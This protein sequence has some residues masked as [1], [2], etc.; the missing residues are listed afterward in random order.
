MSIHTGHRARFRKRYRTEG[1][2]AFAEHEVLEFLLYYCYPQRNTN[3]IAHH[4]LK[5]F[6]S[7]HNLFEA[8]VETLM[9]RLGCSENIAVMLSLMPA[10][11]HRY[12]KSKWSR[13][14]VLNGAK[15]AGEY[16]MSLFFGH[17]SERFYVINVDARNRLINASLVSKGTL[18]ESAIY[19][20]E[21]VKAAIHN[22]ASAVILAHNHPGGTLKPSKSDLEV[23]RNIVV[24][25]Q[26]INVAVLDHIIVAGDTYYSFAERRQHVAGYK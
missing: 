12:F 3:D 1:L 26:F 4:M 5:E 23:T 15:T 22:H 24:G 10:I 19:P 25:L 13:D 2:E 8:D 16:A 7:L 20:R 11:A 18:D 17:T 9:A 6:G 14:I 21:V